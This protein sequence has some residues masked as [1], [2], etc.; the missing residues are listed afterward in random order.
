MFYNQERLKA[1]KKSLYI[2]VIYF[3]TRGKLETEW[4]LNQLT[5]VL[6]AVH[7]IH[8]DRKVLDWLSG[9]SAEHPLP[10][11]ICLKHLITGIE[12][13]G[14]EKRW[15]LGAWKDYPKTI[16]QNALSSSDPEAQREATDLTHRIGALGHIEGYRDLLK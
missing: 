13:G 7:D 6:E 4:L 16:L 1:I 8:N 3:S 15:H 9:I 11:V 14:D 2:L 5:R 10:S 12:Q